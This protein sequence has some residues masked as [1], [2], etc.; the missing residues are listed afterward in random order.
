MTKTVALKAVHSIRMTIKAGT[1]DT[2]PV[3]EDIRPGAVFACPVDKVKELKESGA[4]VATN[5]T[6]PVEATADNPV[7]PDAD[8]EGEGDDEGDDTAPTIEE[9][10][11]KAKTLGVKGVRKDWSVEKLTEEIAKVEDPDVM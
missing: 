10:V 2:P 3:V 4:A 6:V 8:D 7:D 11:A 9:L 1:K 5:R